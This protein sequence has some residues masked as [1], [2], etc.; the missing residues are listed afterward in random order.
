VTR[1]VTAAVGIPVII[2]L[3]IVGGLLYEAVIVAVA[4]VA[5][6]EAF[7][8]LHGRGHRPALVLGLI[9]TG[10]LAV[11]A[12]GHRP[13]LWWQATLL[14]GAIATGVWF[15]YSAKSHEAFLDWALTIVVA[16][17]A[18][19]FMSS[20]LAIR[21]LGNG[22]RLVL[23]VLVLTWAYDTG[24]FFAGRTFGK[25]PF[26][27]NI[28][29]SKTWEGVAGGLALTIVIALIATLPAHIRIGL[30]FVTAVAVAVAAQTGD[31]VESL[32]KRYCDVKDSGTIIPGHGGV[33][34]RVDSLVFSG[35]AAFYMF[36]LAG[37]H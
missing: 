34:D 35:T 6:W 16:V 12:A 11:S 25:T 4:L 13:F 20:L 15:L 9:M 10:L 26:M 31:L 3:V 8:M 17:Y 2:V 36:L 19:G 18:G 27:Q 23:L 33:L 5:A 22:T 21:L 14:V 1:V 7:Q 37:F 30:A 32:M 29:K 28:S 24:A